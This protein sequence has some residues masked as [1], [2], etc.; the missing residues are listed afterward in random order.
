MLAALHAPVEPIQDERAVAMDDEAA[1]VEDGAGGA[2]HG[3]RA[4]LVRFLTP[5]CPQ[6]IVF[7]NALE[8]VVGQVGSPFS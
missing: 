1:D 8:S 3:K 2:G 4:A 7:P 6:F 5:F